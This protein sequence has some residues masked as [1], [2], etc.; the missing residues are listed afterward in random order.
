MT[1]LTAEAHNKK[2]PTCNEGNTMQYLRLGPSSRLKYII[3]P[4]PNKYSLTHS[5]FGDPLTYF[6]RAP[7]PRR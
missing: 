4:R 5:H 6:I 2:K 1:A 3:N 7:K